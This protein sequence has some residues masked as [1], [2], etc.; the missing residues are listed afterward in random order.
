MVLEREGNMLD[1]TMGLIIPMMPTKV[2]STERVLLALLGLRFRLP[3]KNAP[4]PIPAMNILNTIVEA[5]TVAPSKSAIMRNQ[6][7]SNIR[8]EKPAI[9]AMNK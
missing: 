8:K 7:T 6:L 5:L 2:N 3:Q 9:K 1:N 4:V